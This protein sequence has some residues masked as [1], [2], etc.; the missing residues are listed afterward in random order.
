MDFRDGSYAVSA[1]EAHEE[2]PLALFARFS[3]SQ[4]SYMELQPS[5]MQHCKRQA[6]QNA[7]WPETGAAVQ[8]LDA[9]PRSST[10]NH[11]P[12]RRKYLHIRW[13]RLVPNPRPY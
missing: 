3:R 7:P 12:G 1:H 13:W 8:P 10:C 4:L 11:L 5:D 6:S 9:W 2:E